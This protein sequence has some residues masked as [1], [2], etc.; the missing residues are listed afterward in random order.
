MFYL[1]L[2]KCLENMVLEVGLA[3]ELLLCGFKCYKRYL[4]CSRFTVWFI[5]WIFL[6]FIIWVYTLIHAVVKKYF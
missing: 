3:G 4:E 1:D 2:D 6:K 5:S